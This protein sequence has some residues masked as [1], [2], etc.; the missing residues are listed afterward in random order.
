VSFIADPEGPPRV[1]FAVGRS[2]GTAPARNRARRR[3]R[4]ALAARRDDLPGGWF[5]VGA[6]PSIMRSTFQEIEMDIDA[7]LGDLGARA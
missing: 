2:L 7:I 3:L 4:A 1:A 6:T 5:L